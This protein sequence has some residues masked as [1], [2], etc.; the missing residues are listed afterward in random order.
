MK[1]GIY[2]TLILG[3]LFASLATDTPA[4]TDNSGA[5]DNNGGYG[6]VYQSNGLAEAT[7][8]IQQNTQTQIQRAI[9]QQ[10]AANRSGK[11]P[12]GAAN[13]SR[14]S[15]AFF[16][17]AASGDNFKL[18]ADT[19]GQD[20]EQRTLFRQLFADARRGFD[21][22]LAPQ[23][24]KNNLAAAMT[25]FIATTVTIYNDAP[26][27]T[28]EAQENLFQAISAMYDETPGI[29]SV[30]N[31][32]KEF[33]YDTY[34][35]FAAIPLAFYAQAK[36]SND[37]QMLDLAKVISGALLLEILKIN[38]NDVRFEGNALKFKNTQPES[39]KPQIT[40]PQQPAGNYGIAKYITGFDDGWKAVPD[41]DYVRVTRNDTEVR[42]FYVNKEWDDSR[43]NTVE[44]NDHY[45]SRTV[46]PYF[47]VSNAQNW[48]GVEYPVIYFRQAD[49]VDKQ[50]GK[51][52]FVTMKIVYDGGARV[53]VT[54]A[55]NKPAYQQQFAHPND[56]NRMLNYNKFAVAA[57]DLAG[58]WTGGGGGG[59]EYYNA[60]GYQGMSAIS[61][62]DEFVFAAN[63]SYQSTHNSANMSGGGAR[64]AKLQYRG[65][66]TVGDWDLTATNRVSGK[67]KKFWAQFQAVRGGFLLILTDSD[68]EPLRY[69]LFKKR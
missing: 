7:R 30:P 63:G 18:I 10:A 29:A 40:A 55:P 61:T 68:Y 57:Q 35:S 36:Q 53:I 46:T 5:D 58:T 24:R 32:D 45:W 60:Y 25:F 12:A 48:S 51:R 39:Q 50:T 33:L 65:Q 1:N 9:S 14:K 64:F 8:S 52:L 16:T 21:A 44:P 41:A 66:F 26:E 31:K 20:A 2:L 17:P 6:R 43:P 22:Q 54:A 11:N 38:P 23:G 56:L 13:S 15:Q 67:A 59:V 47:N 4:Q 62:S 28:E 49:A 42:L 69:T 19:V 27:P 34:V 3:V 37:K